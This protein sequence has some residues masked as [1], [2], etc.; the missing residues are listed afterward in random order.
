MVAVDDGV[1]GAAGAGLE[2]RLE[3]IEEVGVVEADLPGELGEAVAVELPRPGEGGGGGGW[4]ERDAVV[5]VGAVEGG[6]RVDVVGEGDGV[7][8][9]ASGGGA[10]GRGCNGKNRPFCMKESD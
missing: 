6:V 9:P 4:L 5:P 7:G 8:A 1:A 3:L 2:A 10:R